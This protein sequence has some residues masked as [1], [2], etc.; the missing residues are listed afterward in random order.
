MGGKTPQET[1]NQILERY[2]GSQVSDLPHGS[3]LY[4]EYDPELV[5]ALHLPGPQFPHL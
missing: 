4:V 3:T 1:L 2:N 5:N